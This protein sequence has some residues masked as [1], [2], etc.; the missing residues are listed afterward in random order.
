MSILTLD[1]Y[2]GSVKQ[3]L[4]WIKTAAR[5]TAGVSHFSLFDIAGVPGAGVLAIGNT[6]NGVV[7]T[8]AVAG[9]PAMNVFGALGYVSKVEF[10]NIVAGRIT[11]FDRLFAAGA[12]AFNANVTL[13]SQPSYANRLPLTDYKGLEI[14]FEAVT[15]FTGNPSIAVTYTNQDGVT[16]RTTGTVAFG[17]APTLG[18]CIQFPLQSGDTGIQKIESVVAT[19][20]TVGT[21]NLMVMRRLWSS[22]IIVA[23][24]ADV[25]DL[26]RTGMPQ[27]YNTSALYVLVSP[28]GV[29]SG[30]PELNIEV[31]DG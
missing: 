29:S 13:A 12:Y 21:F 26:L 20:A 9:Y 4:A 2:I 24:D 30:L 15:A 7:P 16:G 5:T 8:S 23:N 28:D 1:N 14:W 6:A 19:V 10:A 27:I 18:R 31:S 25:H 3:R 11:L 17:L 22:R